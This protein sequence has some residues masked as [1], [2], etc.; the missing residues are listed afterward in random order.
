MEL[1]IFHSLTDIHPRKK[2]LDDEGL[3]T[4]CKTTHVTP[5]KEKRSILFSPN[6]YE[7]FTTRKK[8][9]IHYMT[10]IV[11]DIDHKKPTQEVIQDVIAKLPPIVVHVYTTWSHTLEIPRWRL[12][13]PFQDKINMS[14]WENIF[15]RT[16]KLFN[17][18][19]VDMSSKNPAAIYFAPYLKDTD[20][21]FYS[22]SWIID[23]NYL[24]SKD[25]P[26]L[27][28]KIQKQPSA[29]AHLDTDAKI[30]DALNCIDADISY[31][32]WI[33]IGMALHH[34][35]GEMA[36]P[37]WDNWS[38][39]G[40]KYPRS[41]E[42]STKNHWRSFKSSAS[43]IT[44]GTL[45]KI[46]QEYGFNPKP[47]SYFGG[48]RRE[49]FIASHLN[50]TEEYSEEDDDIDEVIDDKYFNF[51]NFSKTD[52]YSVPPGLV[53]NLFKWFELRSLYN[54]PSYSLSATIALS[55]FILRN[56]VKTSTFLRTNFL[57]LTLGYSGS[58]KTHT[59]KGIL[60][61]LKFLKLEKFF[62]SRLGSYQG[63]IETLHKNQ[64]QLF[65]VQDEASYEMKAHSS[66]SV[67]NHE[68]RIQEFK[69]KTF[70]CQPLTMDAIK[71][72][73]LVTLN[74]SFFCEFSTATEGILQYFSQGDVTNGLLPRYFLI[75]AEKKFSEEN[76]NPVFE[77]TKEL[78]ESLVEL[79]NFS[80]KMSPSIAI[81]TFEAEQYFLS[82]K[83]CINS[84]IKKSRDNDLKYDAIFA[85]MAEHAQ[86]LALIT[87]YK[88]FNKPNPDDFTYE[89]NL[90]G[91]KWAISVVV[92]SARHLL[93]TIDEDFF[94]N[95]IEENHKRVLNIIRE[96]SR[97]SKVKDA[98]LRKRDIYQ[99]CRFISTQLLENLLLRY[100]IENL[101]E[102]K[103]G[104]KGGK[105][106]LV[107]VKQKGEKKNAT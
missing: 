36:F 66:K 85:R 37:I 100:E 1:S 92:S 43:P 74:D 86:K 47:E 48:L 32:E 44:I 28:K 68:M 84:Y 72:T 87:V 93:K 61:I 26:I 35:W 94:E 54:N 9:N 41:G 103:V 90:E 69:M 27:P 24:T 71:G 23:R 3:Q 59:L 22:E 38:L 40:M 39:R 56:Y 21:L 25:L 91:I 97:K 51:E 89:I 105:G 4:F 50:K 83:N 30:I 81:L 107:R 67:S 17:H 62:V 16:Y 10:G 49:D 33:K 8:E 95:I 78:H 70:S 82:F 5:S 31:D 11:F 76:T 14:E 79:M 55:G 13:I 99:K 75:K 65:L 104:A 64:G 18:S 7:P 88:N 102:L 52:I 96:I 101:V 77:F 53:N 2:E 6:V 106:I 58:G 42:T 12:I 29:T 15:E 20:S 19:A 73:D 98:W 63:A 57:V 60:E 46:A 34:E 45:Y 80:T